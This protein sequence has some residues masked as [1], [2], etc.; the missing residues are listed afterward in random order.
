MEGWRMD[1][2]E[3]TKEQ[4]SVVI[5]FIKRW[6]VDSPELVAELLDHYCELAIEEMANGRGFEE[7]VQSWK[8]KST[9]KSLR[10]I[11]SSY[12]NGLNKQWQKDLWSA[13]KWTF[14]SKPLFVLVPLYIAFFFL[15]R[16]GD[17]LY[18]LNMVVGI[19]AACSLFISVY[20]ISINKRRNRLN[21]FKRIGSLAMGNAIIAFNILASLD[22]YIGN[23]PLDTARAMVFAAVMLVTF[24]LDFAAYKLFTMKQR[25]TAHITDEILE[26]FK[27][28]K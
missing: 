18:W 1:S 20:F 3:L 19:K 5:D 21:G 15:S 8:T 9:L 6:G 10:K 4:E 7:I 26:E 28:Q 25:E 16:Q 22:G 12:S 11:Q 24:V 13:I 23:P 14:T 2:I 27:L 17:T